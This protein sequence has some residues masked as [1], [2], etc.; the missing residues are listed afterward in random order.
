MGYPTRKLWHWMIAK[1]IK[2]KLNIV[3]FVTLTLLVM[4][5]CTKPFDIH[6]IHGS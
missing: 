6:A 2:A 1:Q 5:Y 3:P 4:I